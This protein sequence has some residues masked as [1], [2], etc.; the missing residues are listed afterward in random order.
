MLMFPAI[1]ANLV[2]AEPATLP[3]S[4]AQ[5]GMWVGEQLAPPGAIF[6]VAEAI[7]LD[8]EIDP[9]LL[10]TALRLLTEE[11]ETT[12][13]RLV[14]GV[15]LP[16]QIVMPTY[17]HPIDV[18]DFSTDVDPR[19]AARRFM[20]DE[21]SGKPDFENGPLWFSAILK[22]S[23]RS[24][25]WYHR[26]HH[27]VLDGFSGGMIVQRVAELYSALRQQRDPVPA[28]LT[29]LGA[30]AA[31]DEAYRSSDRFFKDQAYW[32]THLA[33]LPEAVTLSHQTRPLQGGLL[34]ATAHLPNALVLQLRE[35]L[36]GTAITLPQALIGLVAI[37]YHRISGVADLVLGMP[38]T[39]RF[40]GI[41]RRCPGMV[42]N[43]VPIRL[44]F[45]PDDTIATMFAQT[46]RVVRQALRHQQYRYEDLRRDLNRLKHGQ[47]IARIGVNIEPFDFSF[48][49][50]GV[51]VVLD[52]LCNSQM[53]DL[54]IFVYDRHDGGGLRI[55][56]DANPALYSQAELGRHKQ[57]LCRLIA[58]AVQ[59]LEVP[60]V[61]LDLLST[62]DRARI[63]HQWNDTAP[64]A[65]STDPDV[66]TLFRRQALMTPDAP[67]VLS[68]AGCL[69]DYRE[70]DRR[71][72]TLA[73]RLTDGGISAG[74]L[75]AVALPRSELL[76]EALLAILR[77]GAAY[78]PLD[79]DGP[80]ER[81]AMILADAR[82]ALVLTV[83]RHAARF[84]GL[85]MRCLL[86]DRPPGIVAGMVPD[87]PL[88]PAATAYVIYTSGSTGR[89]KGVCVSHANLSNFLQGMV[90]LLQPGAHDRLLSV[91]TATFDIAG[92]EL[93]LPLI[94]GGRL[95][96]ATG[97]T[98]RDPLALGRLIAAHG[99][100]VL[101]ATPSL[102]RSLL[103]NRAAVLSGVHALVGGEP[104]SA[105]LAG[106]MLERCGLVINMYGPTETTIWS[107]AMRLSAGDIEPPPI[108]RPIRNT[109]V[110]VLDGRMRPVP[111]GVAGMLYI[112]GAG[113]AQGYLNRP[114]RT[115]E[116]FGPDPFSDDG[117]SAGRLYRTGD[118]ARWRADGVLVYLGREDQ[119]VKLHGYR[120]EL[121]EIETAL[122]RHRAVADAVVAVRPDLRGEPAL[123]AYVVI[124]PGQDGVSDAALR[125]HLSRHVPDHMI[126]S[127]FMTLDAL[128][129]NG[130]GKID[131]IALPEPFWADRMVVL[132]EEPRTETER[133]L[134]VIWQAVLGRQGIGIH[135][136]FF[137]L[138]GDSLSAA[139]MLVE[140]AETFSV[141]IPL[142]SLFRA[143]TIADL[144]SVLDG[145]RTTGSLD[146]LLPL[147]QAGEKP[148]LFC[149][150]PITGI[151]WAYAALT[152]QVDAGRPL[153]ALQ[154][155]GLV[156]QMAADASYP[157][158]IEEMAVSYVAEIRTLQPEGPYHLLGWSLGGLV[159]HAMA[160]QLRQD[161]H[162]VA[163]LGLLDS[164]PFRIGDEAD[165]I[166]E[167]AQVRLALQFL[168]LHQNPQDPGAT[169]PDTMAG[170][171]DFLCMKYD[172]LSQ[173]VMQAIMRT[174]E[175]IVA[176]LEQVVGN[177]LALARRYAPK[178]VDVDAVFL[179]ASVRTGTGLDSVIEYQ[180]S[181]WQDLVRTLSIYEV[182]CHH[183]EILSAGAVDQ[184][185]LVLRT[186]LKAASAIAASA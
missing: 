94:S 4:T 46:A 178:P 95:V 136:N 129:L 40:G 126:P 181:V 168:G 58:Q 5:R 31:A 12:R 132:P 65:T 130:S 44:R 22:L 99:I 38:V 163:F 42:A 66:V 86:L 151:G 144:A 90:D 137:G 110:Y 124:P 121:G 32:H 9:I 165:A 93:F 186:H 56:L 15:G 177:N 149:V 179:S 169:I 148:P 113:V 139:Q 104:L 161:G 135:D 81:L 105:E 128:P 33:D 26:A 157:Q 112:G 59:D 35:R 60:V 140:I 108:G 160:V 55:D 36:S 116:S 71:C 19:G 106:R 37:Y 107:T 70:L 159:V 171:A 24:W 41:M 185:G 98:V 92:L 49:F 63:L 69:L 77:A 138:G 10:Q 43:A 84:E 6:N 172:L 68:E 1:E 109:R 57:L 18:H 72:A 74:T 48:D 153:Y 142:D 100:T 114:E 101:Q 167:A 11:V 87:A 111:E 25:Y 118:L 14:R 182:D 117:H 176:R 62:D 27:I 120:I 21:L 29:S 183:Q 20:M 82:P 47:Q 184:V 89:P 23:D 145:G 170:L 52:N 50:D 123:V 17:E 8:G 13:V 61:E 67:A 7:G 102:W 155:K 88:D 80:P 147:S 173:P 45:A 3:L 30:L 175:G 83:E 127:L 150:H 34:R 73:A 76:P 146:T 103:A 162:E 180:P 79:P 122:Q 91:T 141:E 16:R 152:S 54:T 64:L 158:T 154:A 2:V 174:D 75:V 134:F 51:P 119:Q 143:A 115:G 97:C 96:I 164:Y 85:G 131:R 53:E 28:G 39:G 166:D 156:Q 78:L 133:Q 125:L